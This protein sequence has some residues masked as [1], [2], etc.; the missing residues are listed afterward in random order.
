MNKSKTKL[1]L[2][3]IEEPE[4][5]LCHSNLMK[6]LD[7]IKKQIE[8]NQ[9]II[10]THNNLITSRLNLNNVIWIDKEKS[11]SLSDI[12][13]KI[14]K[15]FEKVDNNNFLQ[16]LLAKKIILV[17][18]ATEYLLI[19]SIYKKITGAEIESEEITV[20]SCNGIS[21]QNYLEIG[22]ETKKKIAVIT[23][24]DCSQKRID[25][26][27]DFNKKNDLQH[28]FMDKDI[29][30]WTWEVCIYNLNEEKLKEII[31]IDEKFDYKFNGKSYEKHL[32]KMLNTKVETAYDMLSYNFEFEIPKYV[33]EAIAWIRN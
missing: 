11:K 17:E 33:K 3:M 18:G 6:M 20:I 32:G 29:E 12:D 31:K 24:N 26:M 5:H 30:N 25:K 7:Q 1:D 19:P 9:I 8:N 15:F 14:S 21:Y 23:D 22:S 28:I 16:L 10:T 13:S 2:V 27:N 4:N